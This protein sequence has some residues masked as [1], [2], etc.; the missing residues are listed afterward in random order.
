MD[1][2]FLLLC[3]TII[4]FVIVYSTGPL[5]VI[6]KMGEVPWTKN[7]NIKSFALFIYLL[8]LQIYALLFLMP[9]IYR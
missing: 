6:S 3:V 8:G 2:D 5:L 9:N 1:I 7:W 4:T